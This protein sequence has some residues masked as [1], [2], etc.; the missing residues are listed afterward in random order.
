MN[1]ES[2]KQRL[3][4]ADDSIDQ[5]FALMDLVLD[6]NITT[7]ASP[8][9]ARLQTAHALACVAAAKAA[10]LRDYLR[11]ESEHA[12]REAYKNNP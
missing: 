8:L 9:Y 7:Q 1:A 4:Q 10:S 3:E 11:A 2:P 6:E 5:A 12:T